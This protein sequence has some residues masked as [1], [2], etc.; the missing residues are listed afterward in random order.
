MIA[1]TPEDLMEKGQG[2]CS[3]YTH[4]EIHPAMILGEP[5]HPLPNTE[6]E[7]LSHNLF[8]T[9][10]ASVSSFG[11]HQNVNT[12][13]STVAYDYFK[14]SIIMFN[15]PARSLASACS[16]SKFVT[17]RC[18]T[19]VNATVIKIMIHFMCGVQVCVP[20]S[21]RSPTT[22]SLPGTPTSLPW[23]SRP[24]V[25]TSPISTSVWTP[26]HTFSI[27][28]RNLWSPRAQW[29]TS[30]SGSSPPVGAYVLCPVCYSTLSKALRCKIFRSSAQKFSTTMNKNLDTSS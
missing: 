28:P 19:C 5:R 20:A 13:L 25:S 17:S 27:T 2:Y 4:C 8:Q 3:T 24:W 18:K 9:R 6:S 16:V 15:I 23:G 1:M 29:N 22:T 21:F 26:W 11:T 30:A 14:K 10:P 7:R 12:S